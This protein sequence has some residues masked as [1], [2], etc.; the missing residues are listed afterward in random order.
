ME[1]VRN[2]GKTLSLRRSSSA[3]QNAAGAVKYHSSEPPPQLSL[4][5]VE[6][7]LNMH[8]YN[9]LFEPDKQHGAATEDAIGE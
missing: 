7:R 9:G 2:I 6:T 8:Q 5:N 4:S 3:N 1:H